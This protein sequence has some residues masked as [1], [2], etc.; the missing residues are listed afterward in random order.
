[1]FAKSVEVMSVKMTV[2]FINVK[3]IIDLL[4][5]IFIFKSEEWKDYI[6]R[7]D[8]YK[9]KYRFVIRI[10]ESNSKLNL[11]KNQKPTVNKV[12]YEVWDREDGNGVD[13]VVALCLE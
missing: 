2:E 8:K 5:S 6:L 10:N 9:E 13:Y 4:E 11:N 12:L 7:C 3:Q 1:M